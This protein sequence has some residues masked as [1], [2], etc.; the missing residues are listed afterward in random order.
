MRS[1]LETVNVG[2]AREICSLSFPDARQ[3]TLSILE[4]TAELLSNQIEKLLPDG[5][6]IS[7]PEVSQSQIDTLDRQY[8]DLEKAG[9]LTASQA[10]FAAARFLSA[11]R[12]YQIASGPFDLCEAAYEALTVGDQTAQS[13]AS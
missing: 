12:L 3:R 7:T 2:L 6:N 4:R 5:Q 8:F 10:A 9:E 11:V 13:I 1:R